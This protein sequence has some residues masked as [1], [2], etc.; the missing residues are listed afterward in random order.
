MVF[1]VG[2]LVVF[3][4]TD[5]NLRTAFPLEDLRDFFWMDM[6]LPPARRCCEL[7]LKLCTEDA[8][9]PG[10]PSTHAVLRKETV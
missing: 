9:N 4:A 2:D 7:H 10:A 6:V 5:R 1:P 8:K 3:L